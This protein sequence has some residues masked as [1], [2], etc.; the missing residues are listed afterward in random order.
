MIMQLTR[1]LL[2]TALIAAPVRAAEPPAREPV[3]LRADRVEINQK[4]STSRYQGRV[5]LTQGTLRVT[6]DRAEARGHKETV[7]HVTAD[8]RPTTFRY[9][10]EN[11]PE[12][13]EGEARHAEYDLVTRQLDLTGAVEVRQ[14]QNLLRAGVVHYD[15]QAE[16]VTAFADTERR[17]YAALAPRRSPDSPPET[18]P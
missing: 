10:A 13:T 17:I 18:G 16:T 15:L 7:E 3:R 14:G 4:T 11:Q 2:L 1:L 9:R 6:A 12:V 8:G 5:V